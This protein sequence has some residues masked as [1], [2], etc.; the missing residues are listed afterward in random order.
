MG[1]PAKLPVTSGVGPHHTRSGLNPAVRIPWRH[2]QL[3]RMSQQYGIPARLPPP[4]PRAFSYLYLGLITTASL[5]KLLPCKRR[6]LSPSRQS[7]EVFRLPA[8][9]SPVWNGLINSPDLKR[10]RKVHL[11]STSGTSTPK[12]HPP[13]EREFKTQPPSPV[14]SVDHLWMAVTPNLALLHI[15]AP[16]CNTVRRRSSADGPVT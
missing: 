8:R 16:E 12:V 3:R 11:R 10:E 2:R 14:R 1:F 6:A 5:F 15:D 7:L 9:H 13:S 4:P